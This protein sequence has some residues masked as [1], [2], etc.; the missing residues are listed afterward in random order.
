MYT[1]RTSSV[2]EGCLF[3]HMRGT[4]DIWSRSGNLL[5]RSEG[6]IDAKPFFF[7]C[8]VSRI[9][10]IGDLR[11]CLERC[12]IYPKVKNS[13]YGTWDDLF[14]LPA[15]LGRAVRCAIIRVK[16]VRKYHRI[17]AFVRLFFHKTMVLSECNPVLQELQPPLSLPTPP[18][19]RNLSYPWNR[20]L[21]CT[22]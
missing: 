9:G 16:Q 3:V 19:C 8:N 10:K 11:E 6:D 20:A 14:R 12:G 17:I 13:G 21:P 4:V 5:K 1:Q 22:R 7:R 15:D 2:H 18:W